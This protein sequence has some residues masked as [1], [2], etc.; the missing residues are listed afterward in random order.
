[1]VKNLKEF[2]AAQAPC[3]IYDSRVIKASCLKLKEALADVDFLYSIKANPF[4]PLVGLI[5]AL[6]F[7]MDAASAGEV[8]LAKR[9]G[10]K[11]ERI[12]YSA[13][14]KTEEDIR[15]TMA[16]C[17][18]IA[19]SLH[20]LELLDKEAKERG[21]MLEAGVRVN[22]SFGMGEEKA[23]SSKFGIDEE[24]LLRSGAFLSGLKNIKLIG[25]HVHL[26]SQVLD[27]RQLKAYYMNCYHMAARLAAS[28]CLDLRFI[29]F[30]SGIGA[31][32][33][34]LKD[35]PVELKELGL[36]LK[37]LADLNAQGLKAS[38]FIETGRYVILQAGA[39]Y[40]R[41]L[42]IKESRGI[43]YLVVAGAMNGFLRPAL[44]SLIEGLGIRPSRSLEPLYT[45]AN[46]FPLA[47]LNDEQELE[48]VDVVG[49]LCTA[50]DVIAHGV[51]LPR[52]HR[53]DLIRVGNAGSYSYTLTP[54]AFSSQ[55]A[56]GQY[57]WEHE[58]DE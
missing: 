47:V 11:S 29:N 1:M 57:L 4:E 25:L 37:Q 48:T 32:Y 10:V 24:L 7:G 15:R 3:Y 6:G 31:V 5:A 35:K 14:G 53:G 23:A 46:A 41:I 40:T 2:A 20:E 44:A 39:Y 43:K 8:M 49:N 12:F 51:K 22:P 34:E 50:L 13:P 55:Q 19:D 16:S 18:L 52:A 54:L 21:L 58:E 28:L 42:D 45:S 36:T 56:P 9:C 17:T 26:K 38:F 33:D 30:G 27:A